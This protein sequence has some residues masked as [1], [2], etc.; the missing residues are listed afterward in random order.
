L[1]GFYDLFIRDGDWRAILPECLASLVFA[2]ICL[3]AAVVYHRNV[4]K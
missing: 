2:G 1:E 3:S 4:K